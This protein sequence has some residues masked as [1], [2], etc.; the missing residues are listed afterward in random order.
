MTVACSLNT[1]TPELIMSAEHYFPKLYREQLAGSQ[2]YF[3]RISARY[4]ISRLVKYRF[5]V[6]EYLPESTPQGIPVYAENIFWS[7]SYYD[8]QVFIAIDDHPVGV[9]FERVK[10]RNPLMFSLYSPQEWKAVGKIDWDTFYRIWTAKQALFK[11]MQNE[12]PDSSSFRVVGNEG[13]IIW[14]AFDGKLCPVTLRKKK[15][16]ILAVA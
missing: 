5:G 15:N 2:N 12:F 14:I 11:K 7:I 4:L 16:V 1:I 3:E 9:D 6:A 8:K 10:V 13:E